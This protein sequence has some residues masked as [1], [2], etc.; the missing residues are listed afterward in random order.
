MEF[1]KVCYA[2]SILEEYQVLSESTENLEVFFKRRANEIKNQKGFEKFISVHRML[3]QG[4]FLGL[5]IENENGQY[6]DATITEVY[7]EIKVRCMR[8]SKQNY[9][10]ILNSK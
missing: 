8:I 5:L 4:Y 6:K 7:E 9:M 1:W 2:V 10:K 3:R